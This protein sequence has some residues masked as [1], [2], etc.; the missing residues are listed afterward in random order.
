MASNLWASD[1][2]TNTPIAPGLFFNLPRTNLR[3]SDEAFTVAGPRAWN[4]FPTGVRSCVTKTT[5]CNYLKTHL[6]RV[7]Y[8]DMLVS[9]IGFYRAMLAQSAVMRQ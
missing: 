5:F 8:M 7:S 4:S 3:L 9:F 6:F 2:G 1:A